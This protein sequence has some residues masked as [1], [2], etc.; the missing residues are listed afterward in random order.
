MHTQHQHL[1]LIILSELHFFVKFYPINFVAAFQVHF[2]FHFFSIRVRLFTLFLSFFN[3][4]YFVFF[5]VLGKKFNLKK[6][7]IFLVKKKLEFFL[8]CVETRKYCG[9]K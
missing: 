9:G 8:F 2:T 1:H 3:F 6:I 5:C 7:V 4:S